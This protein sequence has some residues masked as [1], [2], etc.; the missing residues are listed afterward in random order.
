MQELLLI[1]QRADRGSSVAPSIQ[2]NSGRGPSA[3][4][5]SNRDVVTK[6]CA[7]WKHI[8]SANIKI[9]GRQACLG[10]VDQPGWAGEQISS[11]HLYRVWFWGRKN[12]RFTIQCSSTTLGVRAR[13][14]VLPTPKPK[15]A[16]NGSR[17][18]KHSA[19]IKTTR[20]KSKNRL[21][22]YFSAVRAPAS[23]KQ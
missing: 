4:G 17:L 14:V 3:A 2:N 21:L 11:S 8:A 22:F 1:Y 20:K 16:S 12:Q 15:A 9:C 18:L 13:C 5:R 19:G 6:D 7:A 10:T 23:T